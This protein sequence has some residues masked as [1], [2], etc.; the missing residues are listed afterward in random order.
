MVDNTCKE[1]FDLNK[2]YFDDLQK[3]SA[4]Y[5]AKLG[6]SINCIN[7]SVAIWAITTAILFNAPVVPF[8]WI[9]IY[10]ILSLILIAVA[11]LG[12]KKGFSAIK[13][14]G[15]NLFTVDSEFNKHFLEDDKRNEIYQQIC[16]KLIEGIQNLKDN[17]KQREQ[18]VKSTNYLSMTAL[19]MSVILI[20]IAIAGRISENYTFNIQAKEYFAEY[21]CK[22][23]TSQEKSNGNSEPESRNEPSKQSGSGESTPT[24]NSPPAGAT[25]MDGEE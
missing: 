7:C 16:D 19:V 6:V 13:F 22:N 17:L 25:S 3:L 18:N 23:L 8:I 4:K 12:W 10:T 24:N 5:E 1:L 2:K 9:F 11:A 20:F 21:N 14:M 15:F